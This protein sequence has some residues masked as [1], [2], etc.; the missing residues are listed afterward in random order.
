MFL[1][2]ERLFTVQS[3]DSIDSNFPKCMPLEVKHPR[4][5]EFRGPQTEGAP[6][7]FFASL[8]PFE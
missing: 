3:T 1:D 4:V 6:C 5:P 7:V 8:P 2:C